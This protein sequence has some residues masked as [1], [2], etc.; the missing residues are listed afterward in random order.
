[1]KCFETIVRKFIQ[2]QLPPSLDQFQFAYKAN[3]SINDAI[4]WALFKVSQFL[5]RSTPN[6][7]RLLFVD[8][9]S[10]FN[11]ISPFKL[12]HKLIALDFDPSLCR[13]ILDF[14]LDRSQVVK[15][16]KNYFKSLVINTGSPQGC[17]LSLL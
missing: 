7:C 12:Y 1:M 9:S 5:D 8:Y 10:A 13:W 16:G 4:S 14:L 6:Y 15:V 11:T 17:N 3:R 2:R